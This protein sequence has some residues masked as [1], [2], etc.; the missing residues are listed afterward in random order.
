MAI[1]PSNTIT[2]G[3]LKTLVLNWMKS[4]SSGG[5]KLQNLGSYNPN[6]HASLKD[7]NWS[8]VVTQKD[9]NWEYRYTYDKKG[10]ATKADRYRTHIELVVK[11]NSASI[12]PVVT[13]TQIETDF[14]NFL[15]TTGITGSRLNGIVTTSGLLNFWNN[16]IC[17]LYKH[18]VNVASND[19]PNGSL[20]YW[21]ASTYDYEHV[22][23]LTDEY[24]STPG[25]TKVTAQD[26]LDMLTT[27]KETYNFAHRTYI[28]R[29]SENKNVT[30]TKLATGVTPYTSGY[31]SPDSP[32][33][34]A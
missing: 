31:D 20:M 26:I 23:I 9:Y 32:A 3:E 13:A 29:Y 14:N 27:L 28:I 2:Y 34:K 1:D 6:V 22:T 18:L 12:I 30:V 4:T 10:N 7:P 16:V 11:I 17:F 21:S 8:S 15:A 19:A 5:L 24:I 33:K 25:E